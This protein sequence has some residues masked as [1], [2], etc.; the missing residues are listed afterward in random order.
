MIENSE[1][2][3]NTS[4]LRKISQSEFFDRFAL[5]GSVSVDIYQVDISS[6]TDPFGTNPFGS[7]EYCGQLNYKN[8][9]ELN[10]FPTKYMSIYISNV[11]IL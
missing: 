4:A 5:K 3:F 10:D 9:I 8:K 2:S 7:T 11:F 6:G 1:L